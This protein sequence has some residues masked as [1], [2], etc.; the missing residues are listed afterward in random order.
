MSFISSDE[1]EKLIQPN[2]CAPVIAPIARKTIGMVIE[3][4]PSHTAT[5]EYRTMKISRMA[6]PETSSVP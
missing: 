2:P 6:K 4:F 1:S 5:T 3:R